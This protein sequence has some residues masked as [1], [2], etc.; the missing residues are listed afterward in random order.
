[1]SKTPLAW[2]GR[3]EKNKQTNHAVKNVSGFCTHRF[4]VIASYLLKV[5]ILLD[6]GRIQD[7]LR[8]GSLFK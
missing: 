1:M 2:W 6:Q 8:E 3:P 5:Y 7:F 4:T